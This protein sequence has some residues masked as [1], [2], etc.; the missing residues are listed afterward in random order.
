MKNIEMNKGNADVS[1][2]HQQNN[3]QKRISSIEDKIEEI[4]ILFI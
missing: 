2:T 3:R 1:Y 4:N